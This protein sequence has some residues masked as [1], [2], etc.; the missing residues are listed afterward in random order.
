MSLT[1]RNA[2]PLS[3]GGGSVTDRPQQGRPGMGAIWLLAATV[4]FL[5]PLLLLPYATAAHLAG[6][7]LVGL[8]GET[9][10]ALHIASGSG[11]R[12]IYAETRTGLWRATTAAAWQR[13]DGP[14]PRT[15]LGGPALA[16]W[17]VVP[18]RA[19]QLYA[20]TGS[21]TGRQLYHSEDGG[22]TWQIIGPAPGQTRRPPLVVQ[23]GVSGAADTITLVTDSRVQRSVD[24]G[25]TWTPGGPWPSPADA[26]TATTIAPRHP[27]VRGMLSD[28]SAPDRLY[29]LAAEGELW[30]SDSGGLAWRA[31]LPAEPAQAGAPAALDHPV[32]AL[33]IASYFG[34][35]IWAGTATGLAYSSDGGATWSERPLPPGSNGRRVTAL[36]AD[37]RVP[38][39]LYAALSDGWLYRSDD[40]GAT[41]HGL[42]RPGAGRVTELALDPDTRGQLY[43]TTDNGIWARAVAPPQ[44][45]P[46]DRAP[47]PGTFT[48]EPSATPT[49]TATATATA[50][51]TTA[52]TATATVTAT[53]TATFTAAPTATPTQTA[54]ATRTRV[55]SRTPVLSPTGPDAT[56]TPGEPP[57]ESPTE[58]PVTQPTRVPPTVPPPTV[59][60]AT[61]P[62]VTPF[63]TPLPR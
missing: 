3:S 43:A 14:L 48:G 30:L 5:A 25:A 4:L 54:T 21:G 44:P 46:T 40:T 53:A 55:P 9:V 20:L 38:D 42:G 59:P 60:P 39:T 49:Q 58:P 15:N 12:I 16:A 26:A 24:G 37:P 47:A 18:G 10:L 7:S 28:L 35:R 27:T 6:W 50:T 29:A 33:T 36:L 45:E 57:I 51:V 32:T 63:A 61:A 34:V 56:A 11:E 22:D 52:P 8:R 1:H 13:I 19:R 23:P 62:P 2:Y 41:W 17:R 31:A